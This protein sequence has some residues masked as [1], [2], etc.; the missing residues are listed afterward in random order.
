MHGYCIAHSQ[1]IVEAAAPDAEDLG[2]AGV[3]GHLL[4]RSR[5]TISG[6]NKAKRRGRETPRQTSPNYDFSI[7]SGDSQ[8]NL[9]RSRAMA[10]IVSYMCPE[11]AGSPTAILERRGTMRKNSG[12]RAP[13]P[14]D[15]RI[16]WKSRHLLVLLAAAVATY[17]FHESRIE[18]SAM[19]R[20]N[21]AVGDV[22][23][24]LVAISMVL[25]P[26][27]RLWS[28]FRVAIPWRRELGIHGVMLGLAHTVII[29]A[30]WVEWDL[31]RVF[32][33]EVH[34]MTGLYV[35]LRH[36]FGLANVIGIVGLLY[37]VVLAV[38]SNDWSQRKLGGQVWKFLQQGAYV[39]WM[40]LVLHTAYFL[41]INFQDFHRAVPEPNWAQWPFAGLVGVVTLLQVA[42]FL[43]TWRRGRGRTISRSSVPATGT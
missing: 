32:G 14:S 1:A 28:R 23:M 7:T 18:W 21:R 12:K 25:G 15:S 13:S 5:F 27:A 17:V 20:W 38:S 11:T 42:A 6:G 34:P 43:E 2:A 10:D 19:H 41:Y 24:V 29:L 4:L 39:L 33:Y 8:K 40:L 26:L 36:G 9:S 35:M 37:S 22:S 3:S 30:G 31:V 16:G